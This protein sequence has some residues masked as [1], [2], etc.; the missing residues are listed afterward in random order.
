MDGKSN[1]SIISYLG[2]CGELG[3]SHMKILPHLSTCFSSPLRKPH[4]I[5]GP[6][7]HLSSLSILSTLLVFFVFCLFLFRFSVNCGVDNLM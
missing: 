7:Y 3:D 5:S 2:I 1:S 4:P 6:N